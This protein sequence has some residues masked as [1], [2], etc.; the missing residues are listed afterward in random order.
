MDSVTLEPGTSVQV[1]P[2]GRCR[3]SRWCPRAPPSGRS[4]RSARDLTLLRA[5]SLGRAVLHND[6]VARRHQ[7]R[8]VGRAGIAGE[9]QHHPCLGPGV[10]VGLRDHLRAHAAI[11]CQR[12][13]HIVELVGCTPDVA[14]AC[15]HRPGAAHRLASRQEWAADV[16]A[17][18]A[19]SRRDG[20]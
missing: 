4:A 12:L 17:S 13:R 14:A 5:G 6:A 19:S 8:V 16:G 18:P 7:G 15:L 1:T 11:G 3:R 9:P 2:S 10:G 20:C